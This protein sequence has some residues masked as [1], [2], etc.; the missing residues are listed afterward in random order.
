MAAEDAGRLVV[1]VDGSPDSDRA[2]DWALS[3]AR[4]LDAAVHVV[5]ASPPLVADVDPAA[6][7]EAL[8]DH[9]RQI[10]ARAAE[11]ARFA[12]DVTFTTE[13]SPHGVVE[14][15]LAASEEATALVVGA[16]GHARVSG[17]LLGSV[18]QHVARHA[19]CPVV[20]VRDSADHAAR[21]VVLGVDDTP[22]S[23]AASDFAFRIAEAEAAPILALRAWHDPALDRS[24]VVL[25]LKAELD[26]EVRRAEL[27][28]LDQ[29]LAPWRDKHPGVVVS[30]D[31]V[32]A[33]P[34]RL[35]SD[36]SQHAALVVVGSRGR[37]GF[38]GLLLGSVSQ[39]LL[40]SA[41]C[42]VAVAR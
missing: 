10:I 21:T 41:A 37:G 18:S 12:P 39:S 11:R 29:A 25:A 19:T 3:R 1:G 7:R 24:G 14:A 16:R 2:L 17:A 22:T 36:A 27:A 31:V 26:A 5:H 9:D 23:Q 4:R 30:R 38:A 13:V 6:A 42:P 20:V 8:A 32:P 35:L 34:A 33:H 28:M 15:L 40:H